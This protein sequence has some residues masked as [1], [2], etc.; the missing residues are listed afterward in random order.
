MP[1]MTLIIFPGSDISSDMSCER[2][3]STSEMR[4]SKIVSIC[5]KWLGI[6][7]W[8]FSWFWYIIRHILRL[9]SVDFWRAKMESSRRL[10]TKWLETIFGKFFLTLYII[11]HVIRTLLID[12]WNAFIENSLSLYFKWFGIIAWN[13]LSNGYILS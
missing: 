3:Q 5:F 13:F 8:N 9:F 10:C 12:L 7:F 4:S 1:E 11:K 6:I 2:F